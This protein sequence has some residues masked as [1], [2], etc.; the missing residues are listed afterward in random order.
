MAFPVPP[1]LD[2]VQNLNNLLDKQ[3]SGL[4]KQNQQQQG[5]PMQQPHTGD[6]RGTQG[7]TSSY[8][9]PLPLAMAIFV[10]PSSKGR[11][12][13]AACLPLPI[14]LYYCSYM[15]K[16]FKQLFVALTMHYLTDLFGWPS[17]EG[18]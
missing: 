16:V 3:L 12:G 14:Q 18:S 13:F 15:V 4:A 5:A 7:S 8:S 2:L 11:P 10:P 1:C 9:G 6:S 17:S